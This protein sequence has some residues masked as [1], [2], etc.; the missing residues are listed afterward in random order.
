MAR[1]HQGVTWFGQPISAS[2]G[3]LSE[4]M[5]HLPSFDRKSFGPDGSRNEFLDTIIR[6]PI[7]DDTRYIPVATVSPQYDLVQHHEV[8]GWL[9]DGLMAVGE[10]PEDMSGTLTLSKY[11]ERMQLTIRLPKYDFDPGDQY[12]L[13]LVVNALNSVDKSTSLEIQMGWWRQICSNG[14]KAKARGS[15]SRSIHLLGRRTASAIAPIIGEQLASVKLDRS[16]YR[17][18]LDTPISLERIERWADTQVAQT[19]GPHAAARVCHIVRTGEDGRIEDPFEKAPPHAIAV[20]SERK[21]PGACAP[22][23]NAYHVSQVLSWISSHRRTIQDQN[24][25][26]AQIDRLMR[27]LLPREAANQ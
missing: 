14:M 19:W 3:T 24:E 20:K 1:Q 7:G 17:R 4:L 23:A 9:A 13:S 22:V 12:P 26:T 2:T 25:R 18:W 21:M 5:G 10:N 8:F 6:A 11:G 27:T 15:T 16:R